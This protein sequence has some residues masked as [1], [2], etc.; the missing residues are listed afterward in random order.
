MSVAAEMGTRE[1][2]LHS[3]LGADTEECWCVTAERQGV[4][5]SAGEEEEGVS[6][7]PGR[8]DDTGVDDM[9]EHGYASVGLKHCQ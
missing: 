1:D 5:G 3:T 4:E 9:V 8:D 6:G 7:R 2:D